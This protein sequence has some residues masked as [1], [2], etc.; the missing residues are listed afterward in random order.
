M[1]IALEHVTQTLNV[2]GRRVNILGFV[3]IEQQLLNSTFVWCH[4]QNA[5]IHLQNKLF[6]KRSWGPDLVQRPYFANPRLRGSPSFMRPAFTG[7]QRWAR[8]WEACW[9]DRMN[10]TLS[11]L[12]RS[13]PP[14]QDSDMQAAGPGKGERHTVETQKQWSIP[15]CGGSGGCLITASLKRC[16]ELLVHW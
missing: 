15:H 10:N 12:L 3:V 14:N 8:H 5:C 9:G 11:Q 4:R 16:P 7:L 6:T 1:Q 2:K 13:L